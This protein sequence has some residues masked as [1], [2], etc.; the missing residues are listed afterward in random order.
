MAHTSSIDELNNLQTEQDKQKIRAYFEEMDLEPEEIEKR[1]GVANDFDNLYLMLFLLMSASAT[2]GE[3]V[4]DDNEYWNDYLTRGYNDV[5]TENGYSTDDPMVSNRIDET[6]AEVLNTTYEHIAQTY[7][8]SHDRA[9]MIASNDTNAFAN[10]EY[11]I[12]KIKEGYTRKRWVTKVDKKTRHDHVWADG[13][14]VDIQMPFIVGGYEML[15]PLDQ[16]L[17]ADAKEVINCRCSVM[18][19]GKSNTTS[20]VML[21]N[22]ESRRSEFIEEFGFAPPEVNSEVYSDDFRKKID[23]LTDNVDETRNVTSALRS[24]YEHRD[25][26]PYEDLAYIDAKRDKIIIN[27]DFDFYDKETRTSACKPNKPMD[28]LLSNAEKGTIIGVHNHPQNNAPSVNDICCAHKNGYKYGIVG[29]HNGTIYKYSTTQD[30]NINEARNIE[31]ILVKLQKAVYYKDHKE[32]EDAINDL[33]EN[34]VHMEVW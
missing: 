21:E 14:E 26:T 31:S 32:I 20:D 6:V 18:Y 30:F 19:F 13:Q 12:R 23:A 22:E 15:F 34:G 4:I 2:A 7:Y 29:C 17:G 24:I 5:L 11:H 25:G 33:I 10:Y 9:L 1:I 28:V 16:S 8:L 27:K 3:S